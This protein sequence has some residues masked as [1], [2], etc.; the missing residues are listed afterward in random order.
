MHSDGGGLYL[1]VV[2][3][4]DAP[5]SK[6]WIFRYASGAKTISKSGK[7]RRAERHMGLGSLQTVSL[8]EARQRATDAR[9]LR[10]QGIDPIQARDESRAAAAASSAKQTMTFDACRDA[11]IAAHR[12]GWKNVKHAAQWTN[13]LATYISPTFGKLSVRDIDTALVMQALEPVWIKRPET[14]SRLRGRIESILDWA[15]VRGFRDGD[16]P[17]R[18]RGHLSQLL[19]SRNKLRKV[20]HHP[21]MPYDELPAFL[22]ALREQVGTAARALEWTILTAARTGETIGGTTD[23][24]NAR[25]RAWTIPGGR[26]KAGREHRV[27][28]SASATAIIDGLASLREGGKLLFPNRKGQR[29][30][31]VA[32]A[33]ILE[34][35]GHRDITVHGFRSTFRDWAAERT[36]FPSEV[37]EMA[38]AHAIG[39]KVEAAYRR[40]DLFDKRR[41]LMDAWAEYCQHGE[42]SAE[43]VPL[44][45]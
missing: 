3:R 5:L 13:A 37:V 9:K 21:A 44:R 6:S 16:N 39:D 25:D 45:A 43:I 24:I 19:V 8:A 40:G 28:L 35:M 20:R 2:Q 41:R 18:W 1:Q 4:D 38:L 30:T 17:A 33:H 12:A 10:E 23:E 27:P 36:N 7:P 11:Y 29:L 34:R 31:G 15:K 32:M 42:I 26:M 14:A 22:V